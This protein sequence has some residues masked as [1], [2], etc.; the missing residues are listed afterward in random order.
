MSDTPRTT[1]ADVEHYSRETLAA[2]AVDGLN[3]TSLLTGQCADAY[4]RRR[5]AVGK[6]AGIALWGAAGWTVATL[7]ALG[8]LS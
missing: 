7:V 4:R 1:L 6:L 2:L 3:M 8:V 5:W